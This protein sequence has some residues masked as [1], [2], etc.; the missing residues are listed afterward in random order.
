MSDNLT[1]PE[2]KRQT[3]VSLSYPGAIPLCPCYVGAEF[4]SWAKK[5]FLQFIWRHWV[6]L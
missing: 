5:I 4:K 6:L 2:G 1:R 3:V